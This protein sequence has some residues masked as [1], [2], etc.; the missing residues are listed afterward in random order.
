MQLIVSGSLAYDRLMAFDGHFEDHL[1]ADRLD[2][3]NV[4][5][6]V[7][8]VEERFGGTAGNIA[9]N[10]ALLGK[11]PLILATVGS[12]FDRYRERLR[13]LGLPTGGIREM[14]DQL[15]ACAYITTD[16]K[17]NQITTFNLGALNF[18]C[19]Y[20]LSGLPDEKALA[21]ISPGNPGDMLAQSRFYKEKNID[22]I[23]DPGQSIPILDS[24]HMVEMIT[25]S[26]LLICNDYEGSLIE[27]ATGLPKKALLERTGALLTTRGEVGSELFTPHGALDIPAVPPRQVVDPTGAGDAYRSGLMAGLADGRPLA[28]AARMGAVCASFAVEK[29][30]TQEHRFDTAAFDRRW[31]EHF[32]A[33]TA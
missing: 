3:I 18:S 27:Q 22:Y 1:L 20:E 7:F 32:G 15:T 6:T 10:L 25:G 33:A 14:A 26:R 21:I 4:C 19:E 11:Q 24:A 9:Y 17:N 28:E 16:R 2:A 12:D 30:G 13:Q 31:R 29:I 5:F 8:G 23:F